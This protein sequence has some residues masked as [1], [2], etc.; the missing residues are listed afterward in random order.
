MTLSP[1][2]LDLVVRIDIDTGHLHTITG[3]YL[4][5][6]ITDHIKT[7]AF[8][9]VS[10]ISRV[11][12]YYEMRFGE[13]KGVWNEESFK[14]HTVLSNGNSGLRTEKKM[15]KFFVTI[16]GIDDDAL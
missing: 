10:G 1:Q 5:F 3:I 7:P 8:H 2:D 4:K 13:R 6:C 16:E 11:N 12:G 15:R 14:L 9:N